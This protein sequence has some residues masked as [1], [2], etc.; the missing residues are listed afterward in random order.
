MERSSV[1][2]VQ[3]PHGVPETVQRLRQ[4]IDKRHMTLF[5]IIDHSGG[6]HDVGLDM[7]DTKVIVFGSPRG[8]TPV[9]IE[10]P[11]AALDLPLKVLVRADNTGGSLVSY[12]A[13]AAFAAR[14][15]LSEGVVAPLDGIRAV[16]A[17]AVEG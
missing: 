12:L 5:T 16:V 14:Y 4:A 13:T 8:G 6:A 15:G 17:E 10:E 1:V 3:S 11:L 7:P 9:M 2:T